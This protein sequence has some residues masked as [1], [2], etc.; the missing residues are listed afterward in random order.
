VDKRQ[1]LCYRTSRNVFS[2]F[3]RMNVQE[4]WMEFHE[5]SCNH[6][7][8][9]CKRKSKMELFDLA[10]M[11]AHANKL[12][13][14]IDITIGLE[15]VDFRPILTNLRMVCQRFFRFVFGVSWNGLEKIRKNQIARVSSESST[16][17]YKS[18]EIRVTN[19]CS[20]SIR[21]GLRLLQICTR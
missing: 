14:F 20:F 16:S 17:D 3:R 1:F 19:W 10:C 21:H 2:A 8:L 6:D 9:V 11:V 4:A 13:C 5:P 7:S 15:G 12:I 18:S